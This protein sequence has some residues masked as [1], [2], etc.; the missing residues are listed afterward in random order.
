MRRTRGGLRG[1]PTNI[2]PSCA[3]SIPAASVSS[4]ISPSPISTAR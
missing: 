3:A 1:W 4:P 2:P